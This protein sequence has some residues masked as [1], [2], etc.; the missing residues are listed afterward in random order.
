MISPRKLKKNMPIFRG[1]PAGIIGNIGI[2]VSPA[3]PRRVY[4]QIEA[5]SGGV[6]RS[7]DAGD[8]CT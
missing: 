7:D 4:A 1:M 5:D 6:Y 8:T 3:N 2:S